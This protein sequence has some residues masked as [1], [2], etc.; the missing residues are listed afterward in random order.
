[1]ARTKKSVKD[2]VLQWAG[3]TFKLGLQPMLELFTR[4]VE[5]R[6]EKW[7]RRL[8]ALVLAFFCLGTG[9]LFLVLGL[10]FL[11]VDYGGL[12]RGLVFSAG[13]F[14]ILL[15]SWVYLRDGHKK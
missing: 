8:L 15:V 13:G 4:N 6:I 14:L 7:E 9:F 12:P 10:F 1:M 5:D 3:Q 11:L 2:D